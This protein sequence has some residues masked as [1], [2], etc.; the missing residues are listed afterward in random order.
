MCKNHTGLY[1]STMFWITPHPLTAV[2]PPA[3]SRNENTHRSFTQICLTA[4]LT[5]FTT[6]RKCTVVIRLSPAEQ[7]PQSVFSVTAWRV[8]FLWQIRRKLMEEKEKKKTKR[9]WPLKGTGVE[10][11]WICSGIQPPHPQGSEV[12]LQHKSLVVSLL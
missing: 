6:I 3:L 7:T 4:N 5:V 2:P 12:T 10:L 11:R 9:R 8:Y 1:K